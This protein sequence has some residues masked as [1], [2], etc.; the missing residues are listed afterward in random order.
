VSAPPPPPPKT[1]Q[2]SACKETKP[3]SSFT[4]SQLKFGGKRRCKECAIQKPADP[5]DILVQLGEQIGLLNDGDVKSSLENEF[6]SLS[7]LHLERLLAS[8][9]VLLV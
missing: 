6:V 1:K 4:N 9:D 5:A 2:C 8:L 3:E 7:H